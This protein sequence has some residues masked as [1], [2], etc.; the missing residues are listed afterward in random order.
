MA[1]P[2]SRRDGMTEAQPSGLYPSYF[3]YENTIVASMVQYI[4]TSD[5]TYISSV[6]AGDD[7]Y[8]SPLPYNIW[9]TE[10]AGPLSMP[11]A[12]A[13]TS[14]NAPTNYAP[15]PLP[16]PL[17]GIV[18]TAPNEWQIQDV[19][20][21]QTSA[22]CH[23]ALLPKLVWIASTTQYHQ[24]EAQSATT[25]LSRPEKVPDSLPNSL[26]RWRTSRAAGS[27]DATRSQTNAS[28]PKVSPTYNIG[29][30]QTPISTVSDGGSSAPGI[31]DQTSPRRQGNSRRVSPNGDGQR[32]SR[33]LPTIPRPDKPARSRA[34][35]NKC[36]A[37]GKAAAAE[38]EATEKAES[39]R[40]GQL[41]ATFRGLQTEVF[42]L[43]SEIMMHGNCD[44]VMIQNYLNSTAGSFATG[45]GGPAEWAPFGGSSIPDSRYMQSPP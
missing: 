45:Y 39:L 8:N 37:K 24:K 34:A 41:L 30:L 22:G 23:G 21:E 10:T 26:P 6:F 15:V 5:N 17:S 33:S 20:S 4:D 42:A 9:P 11:F 12:N 29:I 18:P 28:R 13:I 7:S 25:D 3:D 43:K 32:T 36:R 16:S 31:D 44:D 14:L 1:D 38:L 27:N 40:R 35:A 2:T 19:P